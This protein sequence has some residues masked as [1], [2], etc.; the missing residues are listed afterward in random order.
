[1]N[2]NDELD[3]LADLCKTWARWRAIGVIPRGVRDGILLQAR[4]VA[5]KR[6]VAMNVSPAPVVGAK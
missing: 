4:V 5:D 2:L 1:M 3:V 6:D